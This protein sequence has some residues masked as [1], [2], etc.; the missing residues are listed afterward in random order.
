MVGIIISDSF[1]VCG[2]WELALD[3]S[4]RLNSISKI[5]YNEPITNC[6]HNESELNTILAP[7]L[8]K[9]SEEHQLVGEAVN[10]I[11][12][13]NF[14]KHGLVELESGM[15]RDDSWQFIHWMN[16]KKKIPDYQKYSTFGQIYMPGERNIHSCLVSSALIRTLKLSIIE[17]GGMPKWMGPASSLYLDGTKMTESA[18]IYRTGNR[19]SFYKIQNNYFAM[20][21]V[22]FS[23]GIPK[24]IYSTDD[25]Q[26]TLAALG[27]EKSDL[28][29]IPVFSPQK[30]GRQA[31]ESWASSDI[32][33]LE[34]FSEI[35]L[36]E[37]N[38]FLA[39]IPD[40]ELNVFSMLIN[41][42]NTDYS[43]NFFEE[44]GLTD[45]FFTTV[46][47]SYKRT[48]EK[49][50]VDDEEK[51]EEKEEIEDIVK[52]EREP[53]SENLWALIAVIAIVFGFISFQYLKLREELNLPLFGKNKTFVI[54]R[55]P[56]DRANA[57]EKTVLK[58]SSKLILESQAISEVL[59]DLLTGTDLD[60]YN[61]LTITKNFASME[62]ITGSNPNIENLLDLEPTNLTVESL[63]TDS[64]V[65]SWYYNF[66][67]PN[68]R[69]INRIGNTIGK[70]E[71][72]N[73]LDSLD[74]TI[75]YYDQLYLENQIYEPILIWVR[76]KSDILQASAILSNTGDKILLRKFVLFNDA[77]SPN[78]RA[79]FYISL[80]KK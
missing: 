9:A 18:I 37:I 27:L 76:N 39:G 66:E 14:V 42:I 51:D 29:D 79:G 25:N 58:S 13:D 73:K 77:N 31:K 72:L 55:D 5:L 48:Q 12:P 20:G 16:K 60:R 11:L 2:V 24:I 64:T 7:I 63:G 53:I 17:L 34:S 62:Y 1:L 54:E 4:K 41:S 49:Y 78:P 8:R 75:K 32:R 71:L 36:N 70:E 15:S 33:Y 80:I 6:L 68:N 35:Q 52:E 45:F 30:L 22:S 26:V 28:D 21:K 46:L 47:D 50:I 59:V 23:G 65:F 38:V 3:G 10:V 69:E 57:I 19:Y 40:Y 67:M 56:I 44:P 43:F 74:Y 61:S